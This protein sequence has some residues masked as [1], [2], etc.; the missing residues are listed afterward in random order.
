MLFLEVGLGCPIS[1]PPAI[2]GDPLEKYK[3]YEPSAQEKTSPEM[4][5]KAATRVFR[6]LLR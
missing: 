2:C 6:G 4:N 3:G 5:C 1:L